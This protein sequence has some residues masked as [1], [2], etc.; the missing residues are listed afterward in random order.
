[1]GC[2]LA[3]VLLVLAVLLPAV[4]LPHSVVG[5]EQCV[6]TRFT[7]KH[8][9]KRTGWVDPVEES[10]RVLENLPSCGNHEVDPKLPHGIHMHKTMDLNNTTISRNSLA[11]WRVGLANEALRIHV[12]SEEVRRCQRGQTE[13]RHWVDPATVKVNSMKPAHLHRNLLLEEVGWALAC[14]E[15]TADGWEEVGLA[16][17]T[18]GSRQAHCDGRF[19]SDGRLLRRW[20]LSSAGRSTALVQSPSRLQ[21]HRQCT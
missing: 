6:I 15:E 8:E 9:S 14:W 7:E 21:P 4:L 1:M 5:S 19:E 3:A 2:H 20:S 17:V 18:S 12:H 11:R 10:L 16:T 13:F